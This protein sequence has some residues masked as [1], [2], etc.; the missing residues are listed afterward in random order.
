VDNF[1]FK[2]PTKIVFGKG[3]FNKLGIEARS[4]GK[5]AL[6]VTGRRF[7][8]ES[9]LLEKA[10]KFLDENEL[11]FVEFTE[12]EPNPESKTIDKGGRLARDASV[13]FIVALGGGS[14][15]DA[16]KAISAV[17]V[18]GEPIWDYYEQPPH[19]K[20]PENI[21]PIV[22]VV[23]VA[24]TGSQADSCAVITNSET[25][26]K[27]AIFSPSFFPTVSIVDPLLTVSVSKKQTVDGIVDMFTHILESYLSSKAVAPVS[28]GIAEGLMKETI[29]QGEA[30][31]NNLTDVEARETLLW[32]S[33]LALS[34]IPNAGR[35]GPFPMH[36]LESPISGLYGISHGRGLAVLIPSF[37]YH[38][39]EMHSERL[40]M[41]GNA[42]FSTN[43]P[44]KAVKRIV[45]WLKELEA[46]NSLQE[47]GIKRESL[48]KFADM[49][50]VD[51]GNK[52]FIEG[53][54]PLDRLK[55]M[56]IYE[57]SYD[58]GELFKKA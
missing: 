28:D 43:S 13:D 46:F 55:I 20:V 53:R 7:A 33:T 34:G 24:A 27:R 51:N 48:E 37:L 35:G 17:A 50:I 22:A 44:S 29:K 26:D 16:A 19:R 5:K 31:F 49:A 4:V 14:V 42:L 41:L 57:T 2:L 25:R 18:T 12:I 47:L 15:I 30:V 56:K 52:G 40:K 36:T 21:L 58:Y 8:K 38:T 23:T 10:E 9:G 32:I 54:E 6:I 45:E 11:R 3:E 39:E 1:V